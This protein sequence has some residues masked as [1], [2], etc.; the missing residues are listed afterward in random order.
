MALLEVE[1]LETHFISRDLDNRIR[2]A[3]AINGVDFQLRRGEVLGLVGET[4]AGKSLTAQ[5]MIGL[6]RPPAK[7]V[8]G[9]VRF[10]G[11]DLLAMGRDQLNALRGNENRAGGPEPAHLTRPADPD[12]RP[13]GAHAPRPPQ[14]LRGGGRASGRS[15]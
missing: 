8:G 5:S 9:S 12:R 2:V 11:R 15:R 10:D 4:G 13:A 14:G 3:H 7:V 6:L 1:G